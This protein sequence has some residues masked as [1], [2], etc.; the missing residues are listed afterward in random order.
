MS[1]FLVFEKK[2]G[3]FEKNEKKHKKRFSFLQFCLIIVSGNTKVEVD[4]SWII[5]FRMPNI[6]TLWESAEAE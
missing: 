5:N 4:K 3:D 1:D 2:Q 6:F